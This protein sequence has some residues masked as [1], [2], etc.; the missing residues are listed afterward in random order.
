MTEPKPIQWILTCTVGLPY[1]G[2]T[3]WALDQGQPIVCPDAVRISLHGTRYNHHAE[4][5]VWTIT[6][7]MILAL[8]NAGHDKVILDS[9]CNTAARREERLIMAT[10]GGYLVNFEY[11]KTSANVCMD[12]AR[13]AKDLDIIPIIVNMEAERDWN[14]ED[15]ETTIGDDTPRKKS[16]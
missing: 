8:F 15:Q 6:D 10:N 12:R 11:F 9:T 3:T 14:L 13:F 5:M 16:H 7:Y 1:S 4:P 2:K